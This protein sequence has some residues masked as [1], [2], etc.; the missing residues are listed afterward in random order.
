MGKHGGNFNYS[1][2]V[3]YLVIYL[4]C[5]KISFLIGYL[6]INLS[7]N[8]LKFNVSSKFSV[9]PYFTKFLSNQEMFTAS[10]WINGSRYGNRF[11][12][13]SLVCGFKMLNMYLTVR[14]H[15]NIKGSLND[16]VCVRVRN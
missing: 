13:K 16:F 9:L 3:N 15:L 14:T 5:F 12:E 2:V 1:K 10:V 7:Y 11:T 6:L 4:E 8:L